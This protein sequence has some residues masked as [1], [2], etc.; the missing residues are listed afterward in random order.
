MSGK[1]KLQRT[2]TKLLGGYQESRSYM[3][4]VLGNGA[5]I[6]SVPDRPG[7]VYARVNKDVVQVYNERVPNANDFPVMVGYDHINPRMLQV[8]TT[9]L[10]TTFGLSDEPT[11][12]ELGN[13][14]RSHEWMNPQGGEDVV[15]VQLRQMMPLRVIG[16]T[17]TSSVAVNRGFVPDLEGGWGRVG[18]QYIDFDDPDLIPTGTLARYMLI[19]AQTDGNLLISTGTITSKASLYLNHIPEHEFGTFPIA[20]VR[21]YGGQDEGI[22]EGLTDTDIVDLRWYPYIRASGTVHVHYE[23]I[24]QGFVR[25]LNFGDG[26]YVEITGTVANV[27]LLGTAD[28]EGSPI[29]DLGDM[30]Y[31]DW[32]NVEGDNVACW[33]PTGTANVVV[34]STMP[35]ADDPPFGGQGYNVLWANC[36]IESDQ[37]K[38]SGWAADA[39][40][41]DCYNEW[42]Y[43]D[44]GT[45]K[46][47]YS[48]YYD[49]SPDGLGAGQS[50]SQIKKFKIW[51][52][53]NA[54]DWTEIVEVN[55]G[56]SKSI[57]HE[58]DIT[59]TARYF[60]FTPTQMFTDPI[61]LGAEDWVVYSIYLYEVESEIVETRIPIGSPDQFL[62]ISGSVPYWQDLP[63]GNLL[64]Y[65]DSVFK[66]T[67]TAIS[68][69]DELDVQVTGTVAYVSYSGTAVEVFDSGVL[70]GTA[71][72]LDFN[73]NLTVT[74][75]D[76]RA[77][78][79]G[80]AGG[81]GGGGTNELPIY[82]NDIF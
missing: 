1:D 39:Y 51:K 22:E 12:T 18:F 19:S 36:D 21:L 16:I 50:R 14:H 4:A 54:V 2:M 61:F 17:G 27:G 32:G 75:A 24:Y 28:P 70:E 6:V 46:E 80:Q 49:Q 48:V 71:K 45:P 34:S 66:V 3:P 35:P 67:G 44:L 76:N 69:D 26:L 47:I 13:H 33:L 29:T 7:Y 56:G 42:L 10:G 25:N 5:G 40:N 68:F 55:I 64:I 78:I 52:S 59:Q 8:L 79:N 20:A 9:N 62:G 30:I 82:D 11:W 65:D 41:A 60:R 43:I 37:W 73:D 15:D 72:E 38:F 74:F 31:G 81:G 63:G 77:T 57:T 53:N 23:D 58:F